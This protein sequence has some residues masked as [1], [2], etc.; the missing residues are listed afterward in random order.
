MSIQT[1]FL[2]NKRTI[3][4]SIATLWQRKKLSVKDISSLNH[5]FAKKSQRQ[6]KNRLLT[7]NYTD[8][9]KVYNKNDF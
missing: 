6:L 7:S 2:S 9:Q 1:Y 5:I 8:Q 4:E 3:C